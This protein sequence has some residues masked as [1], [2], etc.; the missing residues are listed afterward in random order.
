MKTIL[1]WLF[2]LLILLVVLAVAFILLLDTMAKAITERE[3]KQTTGLDVTIGNLEV[4]LLNPKF[5]LENVILYNAPEYGGAPMVNL[6]ELHI[7]YNLSDLLSQRLRLRLL[8]VNLAELHIVEGRDGRLNLTA[9]D[10]QIKKAVEREAKTRSKSA[11]ATEFAGIETLNLSVGRLRYSSLKNPETK[12]YY[13]LDI[14][15]WIITG[16]KKE[17]E[18]PAALQAMAKRK[19]L[20]SLWE[21]ICGPPGPPRPVQ[22]GK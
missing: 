16:I 6:P 18:I 9:L 11:T 14:E 10:E 12:G 7:E 13:N 8:R 21:R 22:A 4:G 2:R 20:E 1:K 19:G 17:E 3:I 5:R 15:N